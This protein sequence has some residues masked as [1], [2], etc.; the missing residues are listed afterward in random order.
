MAETHL[1]RVEDFVPVHSRVS[2]GAIFAGAVIALAVQLLLMLLGGSIGLS[3]R[4]EVTAETFGTAAVIWAIASLVVALFVGGY[5]TSQC[6]VGENRGEAVIHGL[7]MWGAT[8]G[9]VAFLTA[10]GLR[11]GFNS[12]IAMASLG[13]MGI[14]GVDENWEAAARRAGIPQS[15][16]DNAKGE[17][18]ASAGVT[19]ER[20][21]EQQSSDVAM[22]A[23]WY[24]LFGVML[25][26][27]SA[28]IGAFVGGG[29]TLR[30]FGMS[31]V[32]TTT[33]RRPAATP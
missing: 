33:F 17:V 32:S 2:W 12:M 19:Q 20:T 31:T 25:S 23:S 3:V 1:T 21:T 27:A 6:T 28:A 24:S 29:P 14:Q 18:A 8:V 30:L 15:A 4:D 10:A 26:M 13:Q 22:K 5:V 9:I 7:I 11:A 16:I